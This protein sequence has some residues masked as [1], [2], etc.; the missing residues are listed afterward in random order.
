MVATLEAVTQ[1]HKAEALL[2]CISRV[3]LVEM[4]HEGY[5]TFGSLLQTVASTPLEPPIELNLGSN[6][7]TCTTSAYLQS[8]SKFY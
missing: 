6:I 7:Q 4:S 3:C 2:M 8:L 1:E 5:W